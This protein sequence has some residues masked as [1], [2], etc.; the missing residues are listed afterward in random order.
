MD[1]CGVSL[2]KSLNC[3]PLPRHHAAC[4]SPPSGRDDGGDRLPRRMQAYGCARAMGFLAALF[5]HGLGSWLLPTI[6]Y[7]NMQTFFFGNYPLSAF[8]KLYS[9]RCFSDSSG[10]SEPT[11][12]VS[13]QFKIWISFEADLPLEHRVKSEKDG[14]NSVTCELQACGTHA[15]HACYV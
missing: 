7:W 13:L 9:R 6:I 10:Q 15:V 1:T 8:R 11:G 5:S 2:K 12:Y 14:E 4:F 3:L